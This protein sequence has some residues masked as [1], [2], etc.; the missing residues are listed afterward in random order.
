[1]DVWG[2]IIEGA[3]GQKI[4]QRFWKWLND[5]PWQLLQ[6]QIQETKDESEHV[7]MK[8]PILESQNVTL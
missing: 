1:M 6:P 8:E 2:D 4:V 3:A 5:Q 7:T